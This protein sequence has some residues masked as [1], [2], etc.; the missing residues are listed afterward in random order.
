MHRLFVAIKIPQAV[1]SLLQAYQSD[2]LTSVYAMPAE[3]L[4]ITLHFI[5]NVNDKCLQDIDKALGQI[6]ALP[7][8]QRLCAFDAF[9]RK[10]NSDILWAGVE[11]NGHLL[12]LQ[13]N[14]GVV[15]SGLG[16][17]LDKREYCPH[18]TLAKI[19]DGGEIIS[20]AQEKGANFKTAFKVQ[21]FSLFESR[22]TDQGV[23]YE[24]IRFYP[25]SN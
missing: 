14:V 21:S 18:I 8:S 5:G 6:K 11:K 3:K 10:K 25:F 23:V 4:H 17:T 19:K 22:S 20:N 16:V 12:A 13:Q 1:Q 24:E 7:F 9:V 15:L 2:S